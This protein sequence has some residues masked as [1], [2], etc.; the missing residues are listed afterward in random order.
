MGKAG[1]ELL[2]HIKELA[3]I[4]R[5]TLCKPGKISRDFQEA[6]A[7]RLVSIRVSSHSVD[8][9]EFNLRLAKKMKRAALKWSIHK[10]AALGL[11]A[12][13]NQDCARLCGQDAVDSAIEEIIT[14]AGSSV[15][16]VGHP[17][18]EDFSPNYDR[19]GFLCNLDLIRRGR[20]NSLCFP[21]RRKEVDRILPLSCSFNSSP[22]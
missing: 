12:A 15:E 5:V 8:F 10:S 2:S 1:V 4:A 21:H 18:L 16:F 3:H 20:T 22:G 7:C 14:Q 11:A 9:P 17:L 19:S 13:P 6:D